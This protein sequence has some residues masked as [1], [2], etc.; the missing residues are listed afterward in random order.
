MALQAFQKRS[1]GAIWI[2]N[3]CSN[4][5]SKWV[6]SW[7][8]SLHTLKL[9]PVNWFQSISEAKPKVMRTS[10]PSKTLSQSWMDSQFQSKVASVRLEHRPRTKHTKTRMSNQVP[11]VT[12]SCLQETSNLFLRIWTE[13]THQ[14]KVSIFR[15]FTKVFLNRLRP[16]RLIVAIWRRMSQYCWPNHF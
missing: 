9:T 4:V 10:S 6:Y 5:A 11:A 1:T 15:S 13:P 16:P 14:N 12:K 7:T 8:L 3:F 2:P